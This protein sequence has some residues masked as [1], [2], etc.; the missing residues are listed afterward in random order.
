MNKT[1]NRYERVVATTEEELHKLQ[2]MRLP[3][4]LRDWF[5]GQALAGLLASK[6]IEYTWGVV[7]SEAYDCADAMLKRRDA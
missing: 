3:V 1:D 5:V 7:S 4:S 2:E 6:N